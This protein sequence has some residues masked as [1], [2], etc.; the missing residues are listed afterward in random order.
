M[1]LSLCTDCLGHLSF[2]QMLDSVSEM[3]VLGV[4]MTTG[5]WSPAPHLRA[6]ELLADAGKTVCPPQ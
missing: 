4:E 3:G 6:D 5:G 1:R 2:E